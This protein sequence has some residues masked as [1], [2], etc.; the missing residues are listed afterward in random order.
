VR[1]LYFDA[2]SG[3]S[4]DMTVGA[5][6]ALGVPIR[7]VREE[8][9]RL[10]LRGYEIAAESV[11]VN[12]I[13]AQHFAVRIEHHEHAHHHRPY[14]EIR[15]MLERAGLTELIARNALAIFAAL[16]TAEARVHDIAPDDVEFHEVG[17]VDAIVDVV[18]AAAGF[19]ELGVE[20]AYV[21]PLP[22][23]SG[24]V[25][26]QH[27]I[28]PVPAPATV[29]LLRGFPMRTGDG[30]GELVT[31]TGAAIVAAL[32]KPGAPAMRVTNVGYG[33]GTRR[34]NDRPNVLR[35][36]VG[37]IASL[38]NADELV[39]IE[40]NIDDA[41]P[42]LYDHVIERLLDAGARDVYLTPVLMKKNRPGVLL[43]VLGAAPDRERLAAIMLS[44]STAIGVRYHAVHRTT[45]PREVR[46]VM[47]EFG[48]VKVKFAL[49][50]DG[51]HN[52]APEHDDCRRIARERQVPLKSVY[53]AAI[54]A[55][56]R[57]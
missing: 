40:T 39:V 21:S 50:P 36:V 30:D 53:Q 29:E 12:G 57:K 10:P 47:T 19:V 35:L 46:E 13:A 15:S 3:I 49:A 52:I 45:L 11:K 1:I 22:S 20:A 25:S 44:E 28:L 51:R 7:R 41:N 23:G 17:S 16:A 2:F 38:P 31:P 27:G 56:L 4:G 34:L 54:A 42:E 26:S 32:A 24:T 5:L 48:A 55:A 18:A 37:E 33:A 14:R 43:S 8:L 6:L 9:G